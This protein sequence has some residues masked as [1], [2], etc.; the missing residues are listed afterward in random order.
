MYLPK[1]NCLQSKQRLNLSLTSPE[2]ICLHS[3]VKFFFFLEENMDNYARILSIN[4]E[5]QNFDSC[6]SKF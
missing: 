1:D 4:S 3:R 5:S 2:N 6:E